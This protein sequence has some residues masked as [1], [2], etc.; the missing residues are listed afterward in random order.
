MPINSKF[1]LFAN[2]LCSTSLVLAIIQAVLKWEKTHQ[3]ST[4]YL[5]A[6]V[7]YSFFHSFLPVVGSLLTLLH[8]FCVS[9]SFSLLL[10]LFPFNWCALC[11]RIIATHILLFHFKISYV[12]ICWR[13]VFD[14]DAIVRFICL[15]RLNLIWIS[16]VAF[17]VYS[18]E[19]AISLSMCL[20]ICI[21]V[22]RRHISAILGPYFCGRS[23]R[24]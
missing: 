15:F 13:Y 9:F 2:R 17:M 20:C 14:V 19:W 22:K 12:E 3:L 7:F 23:D 21:W 11:V 1:K 18:C 8:I 4:Y 5:L 24:N 6:W 16:D 10:I